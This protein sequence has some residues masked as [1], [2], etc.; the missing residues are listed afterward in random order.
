VLDVIT[1]LEEPRI[2]AQGVRHAPDDRIFFRGC[3]LDIVSKDFHIPDSRYGA[4]TA[5]GL[6]L[7]RVDANVLTKT[8]VR[9]FRKDILAV[10]GAETLDALEPLWQRF[11]RLWDTD[12]AGMVEVAQQWLEVLGEDPE[13]ESDLAGESMMG[14]PLPGAGDGEGEGEGSGAGEGD[15]EGEGGEGDGE[16]EGDKSAEGFGDKIAGKVA[17]AGT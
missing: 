15:S 1:T 2:E 5:A 16:G 11:L 8:E 3:A 12:Y 4:A 7:A 9:G 10:L 14:E 6:L 13:D 17:R